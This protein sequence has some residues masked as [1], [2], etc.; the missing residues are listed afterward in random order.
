MFGYVVVNKPELKIREYYE[1]RA[2]YCGLCKALQEKSGARGQ[3]SLTYDMTFLALMLSALYEPKESEASSRCIAH[4]LEKQ[5]VKCNEM[6]AYVA[7][8]NL[9][10]TW[11]KCKDDVQDEKK[12]SKALYGKSIEK[13]VKDIGSRYPRQEQAV[14]QN[15]DNLAA[16]EREESNDIDALSGCF[17]RLLAEIFAV[18]QDEWEKSLRKI[19][20]FMGRY[21]YIMDAYDDM[22]RDKKKGS[23]NPFLE[24]GNEA[25]FDEW[26]RQ[27][28]QMSAVEF[29]GEF[30]KLPILEHVEIL[31]NIIY[32]GVWTKYEEIR[33]KRKQVGGIA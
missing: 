4:P 26:V 19:G 24:K 21:I 25:G 2:Y 16:L 20:F 31:R 18:R 23:F 14:R 30:E 27:L 7:D 12:Y 17:G 28:L 32:S 33:E 9:L 22:E 8:M 13:R 10:L 3:F 15:L 6:I 5:R 11:Y 1:Y 29:A